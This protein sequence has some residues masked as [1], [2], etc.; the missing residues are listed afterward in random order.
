LAS[1]PLSFISSHSSLH[2][3]PDPLSS[4]AR[5]IMYYLPRGSVSERIRQRASE[6][7]DKRKGEKAEVR[8]EQELGDDISIDGD[9]DSYTSE[10][11]GYDD[12]DEEDLEAQWQEDLRQI[13]LMFTVVLVP[14]MARWFGRR[15]AF[16]SM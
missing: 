1:T 3:E 6:F 2:T 15:V 14:F 9:T 7:A 5:I 4:P 13:R 11:G 16:W 8:V 10:E 12:D